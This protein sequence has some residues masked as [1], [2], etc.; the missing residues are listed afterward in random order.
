MNIPDSYLVADDIWLS[1]FVRSKL[2]WI[3]KRSFLPPIRLNTID[4]NKVAMWDKLGNEK[5]KIY[6]ELLK[7][8]WKKIV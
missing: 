6:S 8:G 2:N 4:D 5:E 7:N 3:I 1:Y